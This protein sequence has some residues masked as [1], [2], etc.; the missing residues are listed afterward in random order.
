MTRMRRPLIVLYNPEAVFYTM[1][2]ALLAVGS[3]LDARKFDVLIV[4]ARTEVDPIEKLGRVTADALCLGVT[5]LSGAPIRDA[6][7][8]SRSVKELHPSLPIIWGGWHPSL[9]P[10]A[11]LSEPAVDISVL[12]QGEATFAEL[13]D[14][15]VAGADGT[16]VA[17]LSYRKNGVAQSNPA[18]PLVDMNSLP[19]AD[20]ELIPVH[21]YFR[22]KGK[23]QLDYISS[24]GCQFRCSFC[25]DPFVFQRKWRALEPGRIG[26]EIDALWKRYEFTDLAFQDETFFTSRQRVQAIAEE[27]LTRDLSFTWTAT[28]RADQGHRLS[29]EIFAQCVRSGLR[30]VMI[31]VESG[32]QE[33]LDWMKKDITISQ[34]FECAHLCEKYDVRA[35][36]PFIVGFPGETPESVNATLKMMKDLRSMSPGFETPVFYFKPYPGSRITDDVVR[37]G[38]PL[39]KTLQEWADFDY[40]GSPGPWVDPTTYRLVERFK[41]YN[42]FAGGSSWWLRW[43]LQQVSRWRC[44]NDFYDFPVEKA[45][46]ERI[47]PQP[48]LS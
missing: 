17:G 48:N 45:L 12:G 21:K 30:Q 7:K 5:V 2:L 34:V 19:A 38:Y 47:C 3:V 15:L 40:V 23:R 8:I 32:S 44:R 26:A 42:R 29:E 14:E 9:F 46:V 10:S 25:A 13:V 36:F 43:P 6:L 33:T 37:A 18:R 24:L 1:P 41:F 4:D 11:V 39:P 16:G 27:F 28:M 35:I 22:L 20:Y 31:G